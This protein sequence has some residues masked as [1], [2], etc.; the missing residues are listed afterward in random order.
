MTTLI[1]SGKGTVTFSNEAFLLGVFRTIIVCTLLLYAFRSTF[2]L[3]LVD[4]G[5]DTIVY[6]LRTA[7]KGGNRGT[8]TLK[9]A[10]VGHYPPP[11]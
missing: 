4:N 6:P 8:P 3:A 2:H 10:S 9:K 11:Y 1:T 5:S 7:K